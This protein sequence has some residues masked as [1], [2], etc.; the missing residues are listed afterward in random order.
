MT[1]NWPGSAAVDSTGGSAGSRGGRRPLWIAHRRDDLAHLSGA[2][3]LQALAGVDHEVRAGALLG[4]GESAGPGWRRAVPASCRAGPAP[5]R[6]AR[7]P[8]PRPPPPCR[9]S[10]RRRSRRAAGCR[11]RRCRRRLAFGVLEEADAVALPTS[12]WTMAFSRFS[13]SGLPSTCAPQLFAVDPAVLH[14]A[15]EGLADRLDGRAAQ[16]VERHAPRRRR[17]RPGRLRR[18]RNIAA[19]VDLPMP[20]EPVRPMMI[21]A[22]PSAAAPGRGHRRRSAAARRRRPRTTATAWRI[23][24]SSPSTVRSAGALGA[25]QELACAAACRP[26]P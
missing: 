7:R 4:V 11:A 20:I 1:F 26:C 18:S 6:A 13:A 14:H 17:H 9:R 15:R 10:C 22:S 16:V 25:L 12:G 5:A 19:V 3:G 8:G 24:I 2:G 23:S 21:I